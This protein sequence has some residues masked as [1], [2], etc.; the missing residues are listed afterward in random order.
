MKLLKNIILILTIFFFIFNVYSTNYALD[1]ILFSLSNIDEVVQID[2]ELG[3]SESFLD[4]SKN[5][6][7][8]PILY[9]NYYN[10]TGNNIKILQYEKGVPGEHSD[11]GN[12]LH[13]ENINPKISDHATHIAGIM[14]SNGTLNFNYNG[15][16][17]K[18]EIY[19]YQEDFLPFGYSND[20]ESNYETGINT[21]KTDLI[22]NSFGHGDCNLL[23]IYNSFTELIDE[24][25]FG[26]HTT[27][28]VPIVWAV[29]NSQ[30][31]NS[32]SGYYT[33][34]PE[35][36]A[37]NTISVGN[38]YDNGYMGIKSGF[39]PTDDGR[40]KPELVAPGHN[41]KSTI[42]NLYINKS[43]KN[44]NFTANITE[45]PNS[46]DDDYCYPYDTMSGT[47]MS[48]PHVSGTI[49]LMLEQWNK[50]GFTQDPLPSTIK[51]MLLDSSTDLKKDGSGEQIIDGPDYVNGFGLLNAKGAV[52]RIINKTFIEDSIVDSEDT[53]IYEIN[54]KNQNDLKVTLIWDDIPNPVLVNDLDIKLISPTGKTFYPWT[55]DP[56][57]PSQKAI[58]NQSDHL[59]NVEQVYINQ[60]EIEQGEWLVIVS[61]TDFDATNS[62]QK[63][64]LVSENKIL[65]S[66]VKITT[67]PTILQDFKHINNGIYEVKINQ[68]DNTKNNFVI[69]FG[70]YSYSN[71]FSENQKQVFLLKQQ[72]QNL[73]I[74]YMNYEVTQ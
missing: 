19:A 71:N 29:G 44:C 64:S 49:A 53:D 14:I 28:V 66:R 17:P 45:E 30:K 13:I 47:S 48:A 27:K 54:V 12:R 5:T 43:I 6:S 37:K 22:S 74:S 38:V 23:G 16:A 46:Y 60:S 15:I 52:D 21:Y 1:D 51:A 40:I 55:L 72:K 73:P 65:P 31:C 70:N 2:I 57:N 25:V 26:K 4:T 10:L 33:I 63:Y 50:S 18:S 34:A 20:L 3:N 7:F 9:E 58:R 56:N 67:T 24:F 41:I 42:P 36:S 61:V 32:T 39:G 62:I 11:L 69:K 35:A 59:N 68:N 8:I